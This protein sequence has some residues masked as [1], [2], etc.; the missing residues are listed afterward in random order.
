MTETELK[1]IEGRLPKGLERVGAQLDASHLA[2]AVRHAWTEGA[3]LRQG[4]TDVRN[5]GARVSQEREAAGAMAERYKLER[6]ALVERCT[7]L[8]KTLAALLSDVQSDT[9]LAEAISKARAVLDEA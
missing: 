3:E 9:G 6:D 5:A 1:E 2:A 7:R 8:R 4:M